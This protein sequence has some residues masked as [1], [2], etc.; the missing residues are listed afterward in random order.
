[1]C[2]EFPRIEN[3]QSPTKINIIYYVIKT[4]KHEQKHHESFMGQQDK[5]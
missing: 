1:M 2:T 5:I 3:T 4:N